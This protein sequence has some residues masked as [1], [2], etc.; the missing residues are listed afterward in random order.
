MSAA[1]KRVFCDHCKEFV[2]RTVY[3]EHRRNENREPWRNSFQF[4]PLESGTAFEFNPAELACVDNTA[5]T[6]DNECMDDSTQIYHDTSLQ[7]A[8]LVTML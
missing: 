6:N 2:S 4:T 8:A 7:G 3:Y 5:P 1:V